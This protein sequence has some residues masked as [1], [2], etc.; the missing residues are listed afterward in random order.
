MAAQFD[1]HHT[2]E[3]AAVVLWASYPPGGSP[4]TN[5]GLPVL[6]I[7]GSEDMGKTFQKNKQRYPW[8]KSLF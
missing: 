2:D 8:L 7:Y 5:L 6:S 4:L 1:Y 3:V